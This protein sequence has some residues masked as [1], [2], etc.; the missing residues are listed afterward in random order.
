M[1]FVRPGSLAVLCLLLA[2]AS[3]WA[4][5]RSRAGTATLRF[6]SPF[7]K[8][9]KP[10]EEGPIVTIGGQP[11]VSA[12]QYNDISAAAM[13][14]LKKYPADRHY[15]VGL[16]RDPAPII[17]F[18]QNLGGKR[19]AVNFP[20]S[21][22]SSGS[23][24]KEI[25]ARYVARFIPAEVLRSGRTIVFVDAT[26]SG[27]GLDHYV[28]LIKPSLRGAKVIKAAFG[29][30]NAGVANTSIYTNPGNKRVINTAPFPEVDRF[31]VNPYENV[32][33]EYP[34]HAPGYNKLSELGKPRPE[35]GQYRKAL[36]RR[37]QRDRTL[38]T[39][40]GTKAGAAFQSAESSQGPR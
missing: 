22:N 23:A 29:V 17:A 37:M 16:G 30:R 39:F 3:A 21:S 31:Y 27:R 25:L 11:H 5:P 12:Q 4:A 32:V 38:D 18:L 15:F 6:K 28:P 24:T 20:A 33:S 34:R 36:L 19:L 40:L 14:L 35:Y 9:L 10:L 13:H 2:S 7:K 1:R 26:S 8:G